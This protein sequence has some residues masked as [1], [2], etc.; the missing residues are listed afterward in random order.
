[1]EEILQD[2]EELLREREKPPAK[3]VKKFVLPVPSRQSGRQRSSERVAVAG[4]DGEDGESGVTESPPITKLVSENPLREPWIFV[5]G[6]DHTKDHYRP[7][8]DKEWTRYR[9]TTDTNHARKA[10]PCTRRDRQRQAERL[11]R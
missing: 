4:K 7:I 9:L 1:M 6:E 3:P 8:T 10:R 11:Q 2:P 5:Q